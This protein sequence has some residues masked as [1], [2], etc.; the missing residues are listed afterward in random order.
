MNTEY[1]AEKNIA[2]S[3]SNAKS[4]AVY[5]SKIAGPDAFAAASGIVHAL[6]GL[7][8]KVSMIYSG[9]KPEG[10]EDVVDS[11]DIVSN[12]SERELV[13]AIDFSETDA[14]KVHY[15]TEGDVLYL[16]LKPIKKDFDLSNIRA[17]IK[18]LDFDLIFLVGAQSPDDFG[19]VYKEL[20][21]E[22]TRATVVNVDNSVKNSRFG[23]FN[24]IDEMSE[25]LSLLVLNKLPEWGIN[26]N[27]KS[28]RSLI[29]GINHRSLD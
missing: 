28:V 22:F 1:T 24:V 15:T 10:Y 2:D 20:E 4:I 8:K 25:S 3:I 5:P 13:V 9:Q 26:N 14:S 19:T 21:N 12:I 27:S 17:S 6:K 16:T 11:A 23:D 18:G 29:R 7:G